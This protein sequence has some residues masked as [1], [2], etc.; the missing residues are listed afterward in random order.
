[1]QKHIPSNLEILKKKY[2]EISPWLNEKSRR[3]FAAIEAKSHGTGGITFVRKAT[4]IS[5]K[6]IR[7]GLLELKNKDGFK[8]DRIREKGGGR[9]R[10]TEKYPQLKKDLEEC[11]ESATRGD[12]ESPLLWTS[13]STAKIAEALKT[14]GY[15]ITDDT[16][17]TV[18]KDCGYCLRSNRKRMEGE[19]HPD[20]NA[21]FEYI[22][23]LAKSLIAE[24]Q[25]VISV[26][27][28]KKENLGNFK[29]NGQE[30]SKNPVDV[31][32]HDFPDKELG[33]IAPYGVYDISQNKGW[34]NVGIDHDTAEFA[35]ES[36][37]QWWYQMGALIYPDAK[38]L[39]IT[40]D[41]GG[42][43]GSRL[44]LW[45]I[46]LQKLVN[47]LNMEIQVCHFPPGT[48]KWNKIEH[49]MFSFISKNWRGRPLL[50]LETVINLIANTRTKNGLE[51]KV[52]I[53]E[54]KYEKGIKIT[55]QEFAQIHLLKHSFH[56]E[57]N[58][59][60]LPSNI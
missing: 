59:S 51:I 25:P 26:D 40:A 30:Y 22:N 39:L 2:K 42:S 11:L 55:D 43:N 38:K 47:E 46:E 8:N 27:T 16:V 9:K 54:R 7:R 33:K 36:I 31:N 35:V 13:K 18:L 21:Q 20:R 4:G 53:D 49:R 28:K 10:L 37:R 56:G 60:I 41:S 29:Q 45:K 57:W 19:S 34:V 24:K 17:A 6:T 52:R 1:M 15:N 50:T 58:Y 44:R 48:S 23:E 32:G 3:I 12:P 5:D 14:K